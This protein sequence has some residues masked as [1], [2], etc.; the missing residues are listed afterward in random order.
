MGSV[1]RLPPSRDCSGELVHFTWGLLLPAPWGARRPIPCV[2]AT[3][4]R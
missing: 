1:I 2:S 4:T 3:V